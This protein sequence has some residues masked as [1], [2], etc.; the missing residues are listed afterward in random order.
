MK[1]KM[2]ASTFRGYGCLHRT[3]RWKLLETL[4]SR[5]WD[6][7]KEKR[8]RRRERW[9]RWLLVVVLWEVGFARDGQWCGGAGLALLV[10]KVRWCDG[11][12]GWYG[13]VREGYEK[14]WGEESEMRGEGEDIGGFFWREWEELRIWEWNWVWNLR[15][16]QIW[17]KLV[18]IDKKLSKVVRI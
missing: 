8:R 9:A 18:R 6:D 5:W 2:K 16:G 13:A 12:R 7:R 14:R 4:R 1:N 15:L 10:A 3:L 17:F 11:V